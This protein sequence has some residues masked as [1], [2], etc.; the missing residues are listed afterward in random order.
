MLSLAN[1]AENPSETPLSTW[2]AELFEQRRMR[3]RVQGPETG[4][5][6]EKEGGFQKNSNLFLKT[7]AEEVFLSVSLASSMRLTIT[8]RIRHTPTILNYRCSHSLTNET[9]SSTVSR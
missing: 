6:G 1:S 8:I 3:L 2:K 5:S 9:C 4:N 7:R